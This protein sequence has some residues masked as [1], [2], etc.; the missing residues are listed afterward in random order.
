MKTKLHCKLRSLTVLRISSFQ[1]CHS[2]LWN[3]DWLLSF[4]QLFNICKLPQVSNCSV[5][6][7]VI[8]EMWFVALHSFVCRYSYFHKLLPL[9]MTGLSD[10]LPDIQ[11]QARQL[12]SKVL[13]TC[14]WGSF[15]LCKSSVLHFGDF[16]GILC[17]HVYSIRYHT[18]IQF[19]WFSRLVIDIQQR[20]KM[21]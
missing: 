8:N 20:M 21:S 2:N 16:G 10:E 17:V 4:V 14:F 19:T 1:F 6:H 3:S 18:C 11:N 12:M 7:L 5:Y 13:L 15:D 9:L